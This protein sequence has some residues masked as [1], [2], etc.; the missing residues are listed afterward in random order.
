MLHVSLG[1]KRACQPLGSLH[2]RATVCPTAC[3][4]LVGHPQAAGGIARPKPG[5]GPRTVCLLSS[6]RGSARPS[7][8]PSQPQ[9][10]AVGRAVTTEKDEK[11]MEHIRR[12]NHAEWKVTKLKW[13]GA[14][15]FF[16]AGCCRGVMVSLCMVLC[17]PALCGSLP[18]SFFCFKTWGSLALPHR[19]GPLDNHTRS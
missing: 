11:H 16:F 12:N 19:D 4:E 10:V 6:R 15:L 2:Q 1:Q 3:L 17:I 18:R 13:G 8:P 14:V 7:H 5:E 9:V